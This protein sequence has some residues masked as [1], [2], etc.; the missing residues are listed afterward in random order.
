VRVRVVNRAHPDAPAPRAVIVALVARLLFNDAQITAHRTGPLEINVLTISAE[1]ARQT[2][3]S[4]LDD[5]GLD[6][7]S[8]YDLE[9]SV[10]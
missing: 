9:V 6:W 8:S 2:I 10:C 1:H 5:A 4:A 3:E 7:R